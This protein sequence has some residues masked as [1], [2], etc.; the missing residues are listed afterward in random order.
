MYTTE[1]TTLVI[2]GNSFK[3][4]TLLFLEEYKKYFKHIILSTWDDEDFD[5]N[6]YTLIK[7][8]KPEIP[9]P[10]NVNLQL[11]SSLS[12]CLA[13]T[14]EYV[15]KVRSDIFLIDPHA[16]LRFFSENH[17]ANRIFVL[18][19]SNLF[20]FSPRDQVFAGLRNDMIKLFDIPYIDSVYEPTLASMYPE[21]YI[22]LNYYARFNSNVTHYLNNPQQ[23]A[24]FNSPK[25]AETEQEWRKNG[26]K[27]M[28]PVAKSL[29]YYWPKRFPNGFYN[30]EET[31][32]QSG[33]FWHEDIVEITQQYAVAEGKFQPNVT[34]FYRYLL[35]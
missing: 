25:R 31:A 35:E 28:W 4:Y 32:V 19:L 29:K 16:W 5:P 20:Y 12:G 10:G 13:A 2:Q 18:G 30:Y 34:Y 8:Q 23:Y 21:L 15:I 7:N 9:G 24:H 11:K 22:G 17:A 14:T 1:N 6:G 33:E 26:L 27:Y 3:N